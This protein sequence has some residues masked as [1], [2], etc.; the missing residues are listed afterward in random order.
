MEREE[1][2]EEKR[3]GVPEREK[4]SG[5]VRLLEEAWEKASK[6]GDWEGE[7]MGEMLWEALEAFQGEV[8]HTAKRLEFTY[9]IR[10]NEMFVS[11]KDKSITK[12]TVMVAF[13]RA[14]EL[15][16]S[17]EKVSGPKKLGTFGASYLYPVFM[18]IGII[19][20]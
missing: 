6:N 7:K 4:R 13:H 5:I 16:K 12:A 20:R 15:Q 1:A 8:F 18:E 2:L 14:L 17:G 19:K 9:Q 3:A 11:R 10:G